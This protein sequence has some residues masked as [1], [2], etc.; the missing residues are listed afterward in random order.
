MFIKKPT[1]TGL[2][3]QKENK[4]SLKKIILVGSPNTGKSLIFNSLT[5]TYTTVSNYPG[6][7]V[8]VARG[9]S[10]IGDEVFEVLD[11]PGMYSLIPVTE[12]EEVSRRIIMNTESSVVI[13]VIDAK[14]I[15]RMLPLTLHLIEAGLPVILVLNM[16]DEAKKR[17][18]SVNSEILEN[19][20]GIPVVKTIAV[21]GDGL[22]NL[23]N[24]I[25]S[26]EKKEKYFKEKK[27][28]K[29]NP[30]IESSISKI[31]S[32]IDD[33]VLSR[34]ALALLLLQSDEKIKHF[35]DSKLGKEVVDSIDKI[36]KEAN[37]SF[38]DPLRY[39]MAIEDQNEVKNIVS[40]VLTEVS[41]DN[42]IDLPERLSRIMSR[43][44]TGIPILL[45]VTYFG[46]YQLVGVLGA[47]IVVDFLENIVFGKYILPFLISVITTNLPWEP[48]QNLLVGEYGVITLGLRYAIA[49]ILPIV[50]IFFF[51]FAIIED[52]GY[53][54]RMALLIDRVFKKIGL[55][56]RAV[57]PMT[58]GFGCGTMATMVTRTL[59]TKRE[60]VIATM[61]LALAIPCSAQLGVIFG[62]LSGSWVITIIWVAV[63]SVTFLGIGL[64]TAIIMPGEQPSFY[65]ELPP[66]RLPK[67][68]NILSKTYTRMEWY[69]VEILPL[70]LA[71]SVIIWIGQETG[72]FQ[73]IISGLIPVVNSLGL[74]D[75]VAVAFLFGFFRRDFGAAGL[76][77][78]QQAGLLSPLALVVSAVTLTLFVP[79]IAQFSIMLKERGLKTAFGIAIFIFPFAFFVGYILNL[80]LGG[81]L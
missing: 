65:M 52:T 27:I 14:N 41:R 45:L 60:R 63:I 10:R 49:I 13:H 24:K 29:Y 34:R 47:G 79:C 46:L 81:F 66:I 32:L 21:T 67:L 51:V 23:K 12:E 50:G 3:L 37:D 77:D 68:S 44:L 58:L 16:M 62:I 20:L 71:A 33:N 64:L 53:L 28:I 11:T 75:E 42:K 78:L 70:F 76:Y 43:P 7:T 39:V 15:D 80:L 55:S 25:Q 31:E 2:P 4:F 1:Q 19:Y 35:I 74:P 9:K 73:I 57:I 56:G 40:K 59:E 17:G 69:F 22:L 38:D 8:E 72:I 26:I 54:P 5:G 36:V 6:T 30:I 18:I 48:I 61:L